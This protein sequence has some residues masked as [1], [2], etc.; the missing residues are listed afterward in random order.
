MLPQ[1]HPAHHSLLRQLANAFMRVFFH[2]LYHSMA[3]TYDLVAAIVSVGR[4]RG[5]TQAAASRI[6]GPRVLELGYGPGH[7]QVHLNTAGIQVFGLDES[8]QM[9]RQAA[10][11]LKASGYSNRLTRGKAQSLPYKGE[12]FDSVLA[13]F[14]THYIFDPQTLA[15]IHRVLRPGGR[16]VVLMAAW[17]TGYNLADRLMAFVNRITG[18]VPP[19]DYELDIFTLPYTKAGFQVGLQFEDRP[20]SRLM[21]VLALKEVKDSDPD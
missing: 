4:W 21:L 3:W 5:W 9:S 14:P 16:L 12:T 19:P 17:I 2:L 15:E 8:H 7:L 18:Q 10:R 20:G 11:R 13:T 1:D 6:S